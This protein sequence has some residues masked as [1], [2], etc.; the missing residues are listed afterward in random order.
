MHGLQD[1]AE[2]LQQKPS[3]GQT[4]IVAQTTLT[5][6]IHTFFTFKIFRTSVAKILWPVF[7]VYEQ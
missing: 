4:S 7:V 1:Y 2:S 5:T 3:Q 6:L